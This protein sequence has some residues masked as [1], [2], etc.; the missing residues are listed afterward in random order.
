MRPRD[1][2]L[3]VV[4][5][6]GVGVA[7][8]GLVMI[9]ALSNTLG[10][11]ELDTVDARF[12]LRGDEPPPRAVVDVHIDARTFQQLR[13][14]WPFPR[15]M[16]AAVIDELNRAGAEVIAY[17]VQFTE[18][19][20]PRQDA[21]LMAAVERARGRVVL[22]TTEVNE[23][24][25]SGIFGGERRVRSLGARSANAL[26]SPDADGVIRRVPYS[27]DGLTG[28]A[29]AAVEVAQRRSI[30]R[31]EFGGDFA[32][33][34][35][36]GG[37]GSISRVS[38]GDVLEGKVDPGVFRG[39]IVV[40]GTDAPSLQDDDVTSGARDAPMSGAEIHANA[41]STVL[42]QTPLEVLPR[43]LRL[44]LVALLGL[45]VPVVAM[46]LK[47]RRGI[48]RPLI[49]LGAALGIGAVY[50]LAAQL[51]FE[52]G[53]IVPVVYPLA[54]LALGTVGVLQVELTSTAL[55]RDHARKHF[56]RFVPPSVIEHVLNASDD[57]GRVRAE[58][59]Q[60]TVLFCDVR[61]FTSFAE[62]RPAEMGIQALNFYLSQMSEAIRARGGT[63]VQYQSDGI[64]A[65]FGAPLE[66]P[67][68][69]DRAVDAVREMAGPRLDAINT[70][71][72]EKNMGF[73]FRIGIGVDSGI[74]MSGTIG[75]ESRL[76]Y[77]VIGDT[78]NTA[79]RLEKK[80]KELP[81][82]VLVSGDTRKMMRRDAPDLRYIDVVEIRGKRVKVGLWTLAAAGAFN[83]GLAS[84]PEPIGLHV[85][86]GPAGVPSRAP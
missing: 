41:I 34:D 69:A 86:P 15:S 70:W 61:D 39:R 10:Q 23:R 29:V 42:R 26:F 49:L 64:L 31:A 40:V 11:L 28:F 3:R 6:S 35:F 33:I 55:E 20:R 63:V 5:L 74:V 79:C 57:E 53:R 85:S 54:A 48:R 37:P 14:Q 78:A 68:H 77:A 52:W 43:G 83:D 81:H 16:H 50:V 44:S 13:T 82:E 1:R 80:T 2:R 60:C 75:D 67:D 21:A 22:A 72:R 71:L 17:D 76:E 46:R 56:S 51:A 47:P 7:L 84:T 4:M 32:W 45:L 38:F 66:L 36:R 19:T 59:V 12:A 73:G 8:T 24:G 62:D 30:S 25:E 27:V 9:L 18:P 58:R 65:A